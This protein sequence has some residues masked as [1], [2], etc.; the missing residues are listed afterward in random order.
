MTSAPVVSY[1]PRISDSGGSVAPDSRRARL[2]SGDTLLVVNAT[3]YPDLEIVVLGL[4]AAS[5]RVLITSGDHMEHHGATN[6]LRILKVG[7][8]GD[9][10]LLGL[11]FADAG[12]QLHELDIRIAAYDRRIAA[13]ARASEPVQRLMKIE[14]V[15]PVTATALDIGV[16]VLQLGGVG[17]VFWAVRIGRF[18]VGGMV[19]IAAAIPPMPT[20]V[21]TA[22]TYAPS[23]PAIAPLAPTVGTFDCG[24]IATCVAIASN[25]ESR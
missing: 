22:I 11:Y 17:L 2:R 18:P 19:S 9:A 14:G 12:Q 20:A 7:P 21:S 3:D 24:Y 1:K 5:D 16:S 10:E 4:L 23:T 8:G 15:G 25:P 13:L 6:T